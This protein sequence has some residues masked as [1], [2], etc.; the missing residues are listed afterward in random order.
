MNIW[1]TIIC[2]SIILINESFACLFE[3]K[4]QLQRFISNEIIS[5]ATDVISFSTLKYYICLNHCHG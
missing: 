1:C 4:I 2:G 3:I 5:N